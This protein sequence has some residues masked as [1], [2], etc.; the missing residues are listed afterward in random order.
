MYGSVNIYQTAKEEISKT[1]KEYYENLIAPMDDMW[2]EA[3]IGASNYYKIVFN[4][5]DAGYFCLDNDNI[6]LQYYIKDKFIDE[7]KELLRYIIQEYKIKEGFVSTID[8][9]SLPVFL[10]F[11]NEIHTHTLLYKDSYHVDKVSPIEG[12]EIRIAT[13]T[14]MQNVIEYYE[15]RVDIQGSWL[16][17]YCINLI[18]KQQLFLFEVSN[19]IIG[20]GERRSGES[21]TGYAHVGVTVAKEYRKKG[22]ASYILSYLKKDCYKYGLVPICSTTI[23]NLGSQKAIQ[24]AGFY[25]YHRIVKVKFQGLIEG[26]IY[27]KSFAT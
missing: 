9:R 12:M 20:T 25:A 13:S 4:N 8:V 5:S 3:I 27:P 18:K 15:N 16:R 23:D 7:T 24:N 10:D 2:E 19:E 6:L 22:L 26:F 17:P 11:N 21:Q 1:I 14:D